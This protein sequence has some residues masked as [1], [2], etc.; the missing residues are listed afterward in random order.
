MG[1]YTGSVHIFQLSQDFRFLLSAELVVVK[2]ENLGPWVS[3]PT[4]SCRWA[5]P[6]SGPLHGVCLEQL[7]PSGFLG[8]VLGMGHESV[9][10][11]D[12]MAP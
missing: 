9:C 3:D 7:V 1:G 5:E 11:T 6:F 8:I 10:S 4:P 2:K 12:P